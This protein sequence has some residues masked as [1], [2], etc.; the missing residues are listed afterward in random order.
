MVNCMYCRTQEYFFKDSVRFVLI[1]QNLGLPNVAVWTTYFTNYKYMFLPFFHYVR[2]CQL[3]FVGYF[4]GTN[5]PGNTED[6]EEDMYVGER[7]KETAEEKGEDNAQG[8]SEG[9]SEKLKVNTFMGRCAHVLYY[10]ITLF[11]SR[12]FCHRKDVC[13]LQVCGSCFSSGC[14]CSWCLRMCLWPTLRWNTSPRI[15]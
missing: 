1:Y 12:M 15:L 6:Q 4:S 9:E 10:N 13:C 7:N 8:P 3:P 2:S 14:Y 5:Q 11:D